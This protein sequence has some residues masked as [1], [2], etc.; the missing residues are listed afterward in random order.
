MD[1]T[2]QLSQLPLIGYKNVFEYIQTLE[3]KNEEG[4]QFLEQQLYNL[5]QK[6]PEDIN[7]LSLLL[8][9]QIMHN[10][11]TRAR[12]IAYKIWESGGSLDADLEQ[13]YIDDLMN[14]C[15]PD[16]AGAALAPYIADL[17]NS[18]V[19]YGNL[20]VKYA[21]LS[22]NMALLERLLVYLPETKENNILRNWLSLSQELHADNHIPQIMT[23]ILNNVREALMGFSY[24]LFM[25]RNFP[26]IEF[27]FYVDESITDYTE[28]REKIHLQISSY[29][30]AH[31]F[32]ELENLSVVLYPLTRHPRQEVWLKK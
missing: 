15:L 8:H 9:E 23:N 30:A 1:N 4:I 26:D 13:M 32:Q 16:M 28:M 10:R 20:I 11:G 12:S 14:L 2:T 19:N 21:V 29:C 22:G 24:N 17:E 7:L 18:L 6:Q 3:Y 5:L 25:D 27:V 31:K